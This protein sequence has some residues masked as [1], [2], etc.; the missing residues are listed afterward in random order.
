MNSNGSENSQERIVKATESLWKILW[1]SLYLIVFPALFAIISYFIFNFLIKDI[2]ISVG[3]SIIAFLFAVLLFYRPFDKYRK[4]SIFLNKINNPRSRI[5]ITFIITIISLVDTPLFLFFTENYRTNEFELLPLIGF[6]VLYNIV[7]FYYY[8]Q[9]ID[10][11][12]MTEREFKNFSKSEHVLKQPH[13]I[14]IFINYI[15]QVIFLSVSFNTKLS[16]F[17]ALITNIIFYSVALLSSKSYSK[18]I[19]DGILNNENI[20]RDLILYKRNFVK[21]ILTLDLILIIQ[22]P[23]DIIGVYTLLGIS[24]FSTYDIINATFFSLIFV[25]INFKLILY[26]T[27]Y[28]QNQLQ[29]IGT[30]EIQENKYFKQNFVLSLLLI[31]LI[32]S[33]SFV[34]HLAF[35]NLLFLPIIYIITSAEEKKGFI[36]R[37]LSRHVHLLNSFVL[38]ATISFI[39]IPQI[40]SSLLEAYNIQFIIFFISS[41]FLLQIFV[42]MDYYKEKNILI[43]QNILAVISFYFIIYTLYPNLTLEFISFTTN[44][45]ILFISNILLP[46]LIGIL[47]SL[48]L[49]YLRHFYKN[50][51]KTLRVW[52]VV[53]FL[54]I[55]SIIYYLVN[56]RSYQLSYVT[57]YQNLALSSLMIPLVYILF[58]SFNY[59]IHLFTRESCINNIY[60]S[61]WVLIFSIFASLIVHSL[62]DV[63][64]VL[65]DFLL[66]SILIHLA[67]TLGK[68]IGKISE[69]SYTTLFNING[70]LI[71]TETFFMSSQYFILNM[72]LERIIAY[73]FSTCVVCF[74][75][76]LGGS[77]KSPFIKKVKTAI[78]SF[79]I[80]YGWFVLEWLYFIFNYQGI[81]FLYG[82]I[83]ET[84][85]TTIIPL[86]YLAYAKILKR[87][88][89]V[90]YCFIALNVIVVTLFSFIINYLLLFYNEYLIIG[91]SSSI[92]FLIG[93]YI[94]IFKV[95]VKLGYFQDRFYQ[96]F[97]KNIYYPLGIALFIIFNDLSLRFLPPP[98]NQLTFSILISM[99]LL[100]GLTNFAT[101]FV[102]S[103]DN[104]N[105]KLTSITLFYGEVLIWLYTIG[106]M[107]NLFIIPSYFQ[108]DFISF[109]FSLILI[110][111]TSYIPFYYVSRKNFINQEKFKKISY[112]SLYLLNLLVFL[113][114]SSEFY[115]YLFDFYILALIADII[116]ITIAIYYLIKHGFK[117][118]YI[119]PIHVS[120]K[121]A[122]TLYSILFIEIYVFVVTV[123]IL[124]TFLDFWVSCYL[125]FIIIGLLVMLLSEQGI[126]FSI[127]FSKL[128]NLVSLIFTSGIVSYLSFEYLTKG[129][130][131][132]WIIPFLVFSVIFLI[133]IKYALKTKLYVDLFKKLL[134]IN[135]IILSLLIISL[136]T[137]VGYEFIRLGIQIDNFYVIISTIILIYI[138]LKYLEYILDN[139]TLKDISKLFLKIIQLTIWISISLLVSFKIFLYFNPSQINQLF[140]I[141]LSCTFLAFL[142]LNLN[143]LTII[144]DIKQRI[145]ENPD[146]KLDFYKIYKIY[147]FYKNF[148][149]FA[150]ILATSGLITSLFYPLLGLIPIPSFTFIPIVLQL[151]FFSLVFLLLTLS[152]QSMEIEF[153]KTRIILLLSSWSIVKVITCSLLFAYLSIF[154][155][156]IAIS[157]SIL[158]FSFLSPITMNLIRNIIII[159]NKPNKVINSIMIV[160]FYGALLFLYV[161]LFWN[162]MILIP[163]FEIN[164][165]ILIVLL[166]CNLFFYLN[167][168][169]MRLGELRTFLNSS[170][171]L[172]LYLKSFLALIP[173]FYSNSTLGIVLW[174]I[175]VIILLIRRN[176]N[177][178]IKWVTYLLFTFT[179]LVVIVSLMQPYSIFFVA[180]QTP[181]FLLITDS[182]L[183][184]ILIIS[185]NLNLKMINNIEKYVVYFLISTLSYIS[186]FGFLPPLYNISISLLIFLALM[187][188]FYYTKNDPRYKLFIRPCV[189]L[190]VFDLTS[191]IFYGFMFNNPPFAVYQSILS[192][193]STFSLTG[194]TFVSLYNE[195]PQRFRKLSYFIVLPAIIITAP[196]FIYFFIIS[197]Y[198]LIELWIPLIIS[199]NV[200]IFLYYLSIGIYQWKISW[201][202]WKTGFW[203]WIL[204]PIVNYALIARAFTGVDYVA[205]RALNLFGFNIPGSYLLAFVVC[206]LISFPFWYTWIKKNFT[207]ILFGTWAIN[208]AL[209]YWFSQNIFSWNEFLLNSSFGLFAIFLLMPIIYKLKLWK[210]LMVF[211]I[212]F[213]FVSISFINFV[214]IEI[215]LYDSIIPV[216]ITVTGISCFFLSYFPNMRTKRNFSLLISYLVLIT[217]I[218]LIVFDL[219]YLITGGN[220]WTS[221]DLTLIITSASLFSSRLFKM[222]KIILNFLISWTLL[223]SFS[224]LTYHTFILIE[225]FG[226]NALFLALIVGGL[227]FFIFN[228]YKMLWGPYERLMPISGLIA[229][230]AVSLGVSLTISSL[231]LLILP[232]G[233]WFLISGL[234][235][236]IN[237]IFLNFKLHNYKYI[238]WYMIPI[239]FTLLI[240]QGFILITA[241]SAPITILL[242]GILLYTL[243]CQLVPISKSIKPVFGLILYFDTT[244]LST[245]LLIDLGIIDMF[246]IIIISLSILFALTFL[247]LYVFRRKIKKGYISL[248]NLISYLGASITLFLF[249][250]QSISGANSI[251]IWLYLFLFLLLQNYSV[252]VFFSI[253]KSM[254]RYTDEKLELYKSNSYLVLSNALYLLVCVYGAL[255]I[256]S[257]LTQFYAFQEFTSIFLFLTLFSLFFFI[258]NSIFNQKMRTKSKY[259][260]KLSIFILFQSCLIVFWT[261]ALVDL[262]FLLL[263]PNSISIFWF[264]FIALI[265][266]ILAVYP[267]RL[268]KKYAVN[269]TSKLKIQKMFTTIQF[270]VY[271]EISILAFGFFNLYLNSF[272]SLLL[273]QILLFI[274]SIIE[275]YGIKGLREII[276]YIMH[277]FSLLMISGSCIFYILATQTELHV[278]EFLFLPIILLQFYSNYAYYNMRR[279]NNPERANDFELGA[280]KRQK[281]IGNIFYLGLVLCFASYLI[282]L[283]L[284]IIQI[285]IIISVFIHILV[286]IDRVLLLFLGRLSK[287][288]LVISL[289]SIN[290]VSFMYIIDLILAS[291]I[292]IIPILIFII[293][294]ELFYLTKLTGTKKAVNKALIA[295]LYFNFSSWSLYFITTDIVLD[296]NLIIFAFVVLFIFLRFDKTVGALNEKTSKRLKSISLL[297][298]GFGIPIDTFLL[299]N[300]INPGMVFFNIWCTLLVATLEF[301]IIYNPYKRRRVISFFYTLT[302]FLEVF[303]TLFLIDL[304]TL[305]ISIFIIGILI[306]I[307]VFLME[308]LK[309]FFND[310]VNY[311]RKAILSLRTF[312][313]KILHGIYNFLK[314]SYVAIKFILCAG[315]GI[316]IGYVFSV[317]PIVLP[318]A[319]NV[320]H[321]SLLGAAIFGILLGLLPTRRTDDIDTIFRTRM[322]RFGTVWISMTAFIFVFILPYMEPLLGL[323]IILSSLLALGAI[324]EVYIYRTEKKQKISIKWRFYLTTTLIIV[325][326]IWFILLAILLFTEFNV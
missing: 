277:I 248:I 234:F 295:V 77:S 157:S 203:L 119:K 1:F 205:T 126:I 85:I 91:T 200:G 111:L 51:W 244:I 145:F 192:F 230:L 235:L 15:I 172:N 29:R 92:I 227:T 99:L 43:A 95:G 35:L 207:S 4:N 39:L 217:G 256:N 24:S 127:S 136:P 171:L 168:V 326:I 254:N 125:S 115:Y 27:T 198:P 158:V 110:L 194:F 14:I 47:F 98:F 88:V 180:I 63:P 289:A 140:Y 214:F 137:F 206:I 187:G 131:F 139:I 144:D 64:A 128:I 210:I 209:L 216:D 249:A 65:L 8:F 255:Q 44:P 121:T 100:S 105:T 312:I 316:L 305:G 58:S 183:I 232:G 59:L 152:T 97:L 23:F 133:A 46:G 193:T 278:I 153:E 303:S 270:C 310:F 242:L 109:Y 215:G 272:T 276:G 30:E 6:A 28:Y 228:R 60:N 167:Y 315:A 141:V 21:T 22:L 211:W 20:L 165:T 53:N 224:F 311:I 185:I 177:L 296:L 50:S 246:L 268:K 313:N 87:K 148:S 134:V 48:Y 323:I 12:S 122:I 229:Y 196:L 233:A 56:V 204:F 129:T 164:N 307:F 239:A 175:S 13:N 38:L 117:K 184:V 325:V 123:F 222:N 298:L 163:F 321:S 130:S 202:I 11:F 213:T 265:E 7:Y 45:W 55:I 93:C 231:I 266:T 147:E 201:A 54:S 132:Q 82:L 179:G 138:F 83:I 271:V 304:T 16:W 258:L 161:H 5:H 236:L 178:I 324:V 275:I 116:Y 62:G 103:V 107:S 18:K 41:Y 89:F 284:P 114:I 250:M 292:Q 260:L 186:L 279:R 86:G 149:F 237:L 173:F 76:N 301:G 118:K 182:I 195:S 262:Q 208:L 10:Y 124:F 199:L 94:G 108:L 104:I 240:I 61:I 170:N 253:L 221:L 225:G 156:F 261:L 143:V 33:F 220:P 291:T 189:V 219:M 151:G 36:T 102:K 79:T 302:V 169:S 273:S 19:E 190:A 135:G 113:L 80:G 9:P 264:S 162:L 212:L 218:S 70:F 96:R 75:I 68:K 306:Y 146:L 40:F 241:I 297:I 150:I 308:E 101:L 32:L 294:I 309:A 245:N 269:E 81:L 288:L 317:Y 166:I 34:H 106:N 26:V 318:T 267:L 31:S 37:N 69:K 176:K 257:I 73:F 252:H 263:T 188:N 71:I 120:K 17:F 314:R 74:I 160:L 42:S 282:F 280:I 243:I 3:L 142:T 293:E 320:F 174:L 155:F 197:I 247:D 191:F 285:S 238:I 290:I 283:G 223:L 322:T 57:I 319:L 299:L 52:F 259:M 154:S 112:F 287:F 281:I 72:G 84:S 90:N 2:I 66:L 300:I 181:V 274:I 251:L 67:L 286:L 159:H 25:I 226:W 49:L 78:T